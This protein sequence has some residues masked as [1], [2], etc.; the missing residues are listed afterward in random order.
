VTASAELGV[1]VERRQLVLKGN[2]LEE[3]A[4]G[5]IDALLERRVLQEAAR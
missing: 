3:L 4:D 5:L 2:S 1:Y